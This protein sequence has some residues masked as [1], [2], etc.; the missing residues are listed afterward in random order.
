MAPPASA[1]TGL[2]TAAF[3]QLLAL[4]SY[5]VPGALFNLPDALMSGQSPSTV[6]V[7]AAPVPA[8]PVPAP[9]LGPVP[10][11]V[12]ALDP[13]PAPAPTPAPAPAAQG[14]LLIHNV[15]PDVM[16]Y[17]SA[18]S[19]ALFSAGIPLYG[20]TCFY[21]CTLPWLCLLFFSWF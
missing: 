10:R 18:I 8:A 20:F 21:C 16:V 4:Q 19:A 9:V 13:G 11:P 12:P 5:L 1:G 6:T 17:L 15:M 2:Q 7:P 14:E 3:P